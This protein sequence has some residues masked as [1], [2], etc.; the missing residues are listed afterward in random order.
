MMNTTD[1]FVRY[2]ENKRKNIPANVFKEARLCLLDYLGAVYAG[3]SFSDSAVNAYIHGI[4]TAGNISC[5]GTDVSTDVLTAAFINGYNSH[6]ME[7]DDGHRFGMI[8]LAAPVISAVLAVAQNESADGNKVLEGIIIGY[9][10]AVRIAL[11]MQPSHK[12]KGFHTAGTCGTIGAAAG[13]AVI[14]GLS[15]VQFKTALSAAVTSAAGLLAIQEDSSELKPYNTGHASMS[16]VN[17]AYMGLTGIASPD[18]AIYGKRGFIKMLADN[19]DVSVINE[20]KSYYEIERIY[21]K[22]YAACRHCHSAIE[23]ARNIR[24]NSGIS[25]ENVEKISVFTYQLAVKGHDHT[26]ITG[27]ASAKLS[28]PFSVAA[29]YFLCSCGIG[30]FT[31][32]YTENNDIIELTQKVEV[33]ENEEFTKLSP[34]RRIAEVRITT[35]NGDDFVHRVDYA[36]GDPENPMSAQEIEDK[37]FGLMSFAGKSSAAEKLL[38]AVK[39]IEDSAENFYKSLF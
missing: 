33:F 35:K 28:I 3:A 13:A 19:A 12:K 9:E 22:P 20:P 30:T 1:A 4:A 27:V 16:G 29:A 24:L 18:D 10:A 36:K 14:L 31:E 26:E 32:E 5:L 2:L 8:H 38:Y 34:N 11:S 37:F 15:S 23:A 25:P 17:A 39:N 7:M 21:R 6:I